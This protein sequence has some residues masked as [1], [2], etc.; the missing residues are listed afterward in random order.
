MYFLNYTGTYPCVLL[1]TLPRICA[2]LCAHIC[3]L[4]FFTAVFK[5]YLFPL[6]GATFRVL[7]WALP[8]YRTAVDRTTVVPRCHGTEK[9]DWGF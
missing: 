1:C 7:F 2:A 8:W 6:L 5:G 4:R 9:K 3:I